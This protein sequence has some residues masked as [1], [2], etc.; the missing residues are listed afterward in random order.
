MAVGAGVGAGWC[1]SH[2]LGGCELLSIALEGC[3]EEY[4]RLQ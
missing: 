3:N 2:C 4:Y 1:D